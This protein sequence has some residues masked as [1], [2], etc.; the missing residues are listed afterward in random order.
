MTMPWPDPYIQL[1]TQS[2]IVNLFTYDVIH[3]QLDWVDFLLLWSS[4]SPLHSP[5]MHGNQGI[6]SRA[7]E[8]VNF[9]LKFV[10]MMCTIE[11][12]RKQRKWH[13]DKEACIKSTHGQSTFKLSNPTSDDL[14]AMN[15]NFRYP[16][17][18]KSFM[19]VYMVR[20][21]I[22]ANP[23]LFSRMLTWRN[24]HC[25]AYQLTNNLG[26]Q[27]VARKQSHWAPIE[28]NEKHHREYRWQEFVHSTFSI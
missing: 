7:H 14:N 26:P 15:T 17:H 22:Y 9:H 20:Y 21:R 2:H 18:S 4:S 24:R 3:K 11:V 10:T 25:Q 8:R 28:V 5:V 1:C 19:E 6:I 16:T 12:D 13:S 23:K 27:V